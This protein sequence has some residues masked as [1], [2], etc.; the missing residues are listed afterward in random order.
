MQLFC[1][2]VSVLC[3]HEFMCFCALR[4]PPSM[5]WALDVA[6]HTRWMSSRSIPLQ[7]QRNDRES[8][9]MN[10]QPRAGWLELNGNVKLAMD[11]F[12]LSVEGPA[13][14]GSPNRII[15]GRW[16]S[17]AHCFHF[18]SL[19]SVQQHVR[20]EREEEGELTGRGTI[21]RVRRWKKGDI[22]CVGFVIKLHHNTFWRQRFLCV[23]RIW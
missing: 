18:M 14:L 17:T 4:L 19:L 1:V 16:Q 5:R 7:R 23:N 10:G 2:C 6:P 21:E 20:R 13:S 9:E 12:C 11:P 3:V 15:H 22:H 8:I